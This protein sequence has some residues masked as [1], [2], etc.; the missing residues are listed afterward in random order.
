MGSLQVR[1]LRGCILVGTM[2]KLLYVYAFS[3]IQTRTLELNSTKVICK[4]IFNYYQTLFLGF[5]YSIWIFMK[6]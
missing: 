3:K 4:N 5:A 6:I 1:N 2:L